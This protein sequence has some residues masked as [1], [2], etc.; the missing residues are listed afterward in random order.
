M[1]SCIF[2]STCGL[3]A[4]QLLFEVDKLETKE[5]LTSVISLLKSW[6]DGGNDKELTDVTKLASLKVLRH[7]QSK[8]FKI[9]FLKSY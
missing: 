1:M 7:F 5:V 6:A 4:L 3:G 2:R 9:L 8:Y